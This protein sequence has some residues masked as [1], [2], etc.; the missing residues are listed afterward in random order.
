VDEGHPFHIG[1]GTN[2]QDGVVI[3]GLMKVGLLGMTHYTPW[4]GNNASITHLSLIHGPA[5]VGD[6]LSAFALLCS[7]LG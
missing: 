1:A 4:I 5:Y 3:H 2:V 6:D 7:T